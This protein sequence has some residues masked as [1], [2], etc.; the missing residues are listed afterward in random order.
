MK[1]WNVLVCMLLL[2]DVCS[3]TAI[4]SNGTGGGTWSTPGTWAGGVVPSDGDSVTIA[5][6]DTVTFDVDM[7]SWPSGIAGLTCAGTMNCSISAGTYHLKTGADIAGSGTINCGSSETAYPSNCTMI[8]NFDSKPNSFECGSGLTLKLYCT[9]PIHPVIALSEAEA[10][11]EIELSVDTDVRDDMWAAGHTIRI[12]DVSGSLPDS[13][14]RVI[15][16]AG[17]TSTAVTVEAALANTKAFGA[18]VVLITRNI[19]I[20]G[21]TDYAVKSPTGSVLGC[22]IS[23]CAQGVSSTSNCTISGTISGCT[24]GVSSTFSGTISGTVSGCTCGIIYSSGGTISGLISGCSYGV[25]HSAGCMI[26]GTISGCSSGIYAGSHTIQDATFGGNTY[27]LRRVVSVFAD[28]TIF[29]SA[30]ENHEYNTDKVPPWAYAVSYDHDGVPGAFQ[31]WTQGGVIMSDVN[32]TPDGYGI[33]YRH[34]CES[35]AMPC[36]RQ[37]SV[38]I[39]PQ[40][41][42]R[43]KGKILILDDHSAWAPRL[44]LIDAGADP[45][46]DA[47]KVALA[48]SAISKPSRR[49][50]WQDVT[51]SYT[52]TGVLGKRVWIRCSAQ[53]SRGSIYEVWSTEMEKQGSTLWPY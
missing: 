3:A 24:Y 46:V 31:V 26:S 45:L 30:I 53:R 8:F 5:A 47:S 33:S 32:V 1:K 29:G 35:S 37:E 4:R 25:Y 2:T 10:A 6:N 12:D 48:S 51:V 34:M 50:Y 28:H 19:R 44:E 40:Q 49:Y 14:V 16:P 11:G 43:V 13:E 36:F 22:E 39:E 41:T 42:L 23:S 21:S 18:N 20:I 9:E 52:N 38:T 15:A 17:V 7:S 27:D